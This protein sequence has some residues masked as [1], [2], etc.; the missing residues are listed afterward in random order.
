MNLLVLAVLLGQVEPRYAGGAAPHP[1]EAEGPVDARPS[2][3]ACST[4]S[5]RARAQCMLDGKPMWATDKA[6]QR[7]DNRRI[8]G[9]IGEALCK[10]LAEELEGKERADANR[11]CLA[12]VQR[13]VRLCELDG[14]EALLD[15]AGLFSPRAGLCYAELAGATQLVLAPPAPPPSAPARPGMQG[16]GA[17]VRL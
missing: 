1:L 11:A 4:E 10:D 9:A 2:A 15:A 12:R 7:L 14:N 3:M 13:A 6:Q 17:E 8:A 16:Q 5:L